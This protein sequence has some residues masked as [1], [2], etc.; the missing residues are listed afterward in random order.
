MP[1]SGISIIITERSCNSAGQPASQ[2]DKLPL[3]AKDQPSKRALFIKPS[4]GL[5]LSPNPRPNTRVRI[6]AI[7]TIRVRVRVSIV[8]TATASGSEDPSDVVAQLGHGALDLAGEDVAEGG[9][10]VLLAAHELVAAAHELDELAR[11]DVRVAAVVDVLDQLGRHVRQGARR[12]GPV[13]RLQGAR[14][15]RQL[16]G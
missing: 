16:V 4:R 10:G 8:S 3:P 6:R 5:R 9:E 12:R 15:R 14:E 11:V 2:P 13:H 7:H 1:F